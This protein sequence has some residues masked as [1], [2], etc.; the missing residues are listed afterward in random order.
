MTRRRQRLESFSE[1]VRRRKPRDSPDPP[2]PAILTLQEKVLV[3]GIPITVVIVPLILSILVSMKHSREAIERRIGEW[4]IEHRLSDE[5]VQELRKVEFDFYGYG[6]LSLFGSGPSD[7]EH[8]LHKQ[9]IDEFL[10]R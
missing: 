8:E 9:A 5:R 4:Q 10:K 2:P 7:D 1:N 3:I 6:F